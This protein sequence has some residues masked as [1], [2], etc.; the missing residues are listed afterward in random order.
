MKSKRIIFLENLLRFM[1]RAVI[2]RHKPRIVAITG[3]VGKTSTKAAVF[4]VLSSK[5]EVRENQKNYNN[6]IGIPLTIIGAESGGKNVFKWIWIFVKWMLVLISPKYPDILVLEL[7]VDRPNDMKYF[8]SF[9][10]PMIGIVTNVSSSHL[11]YFNTIE[12]IAKEKRVLVDSLDCDGFALLNVDDD[13]VAQMGLK[14]FAQVV[15]FGKSEKASVNAAN[16]VYN[17]LGSRPIGISFKL[18]YDGKNIPIRLKYIL[19]EHQVYAALAAISV[20]IVFKINLVDIAKAIEP[21]RS[22]TGRMNLLEGV[23]DSSVIDD[24]YNASPVSTLAALDVL[25][26]L[27]AKRKI[28]VLGDM[29][30]LGNQSETGHREVGSKIFACGIDVFIAVGDRMRAAVE[31]LVSLGF[32]KENIL[33]F[34]DPEQA[35]EQVVK[36]IK[37]GD[38]ILVKGSQGMRMEKI[39][40]K[41]LNNPDDAKRLLCRQAPEWKKK[42]FA[43]P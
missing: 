19:A 28:A 26:C 14:S 3:S 2:K 35:E 15:T 34:D 11:E 21:L 13:R 7:G 22:P 31:E 16:I 29:L 6:E 36:M 17:Y 42:P 37:E 5:F 18:N 30:E 9:I 8:M 38:F 39:V 41:L 32:P 25:S 24:T 4:A 10:K 40:E 43:R 12:N 20:G 27:Q 23:S 1:A 33:Q